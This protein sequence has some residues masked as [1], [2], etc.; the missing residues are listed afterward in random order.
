MAALFTLCLEDEP[1]LWPKW[2]PASG[3]GPQL[4]NSD[5]VGGGGVD[6]HESFLA[7]LKTGR[8]ELRAGNIWK[9]NSVGICGGTSGG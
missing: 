9:E 7:N 1:F 4:K 6:A 2:P 8:C 3:V 5:R